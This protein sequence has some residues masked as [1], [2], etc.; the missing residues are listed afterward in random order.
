M[1]LHEAIEKLLKQKGRSMTTSEIADA[2]NKNKWYTK[3]NGSLICDFQI[4]GRTHNYSKLFNRDGSK[5]S[6]IN[7]SIA[8]PI[9]KSITKKSKPDTNSNIETSE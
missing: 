8:K 4:H 7:Q 6:L 3:K 1:T 9:A 5:V 2:L